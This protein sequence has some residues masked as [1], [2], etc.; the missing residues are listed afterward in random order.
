MVGGVRLVEAGITL[1]VFAPG[2]T[3]GVNNG[4]AQTS[5]MT[6]DVF[7]QRMHNN[8]GAVLK[9]AAQIRCRH[10]VVNNQSD[11]IAMA[12]FGQSFY[13]CHIA[14]R[15]ADGF[16]KDGSGFIVNQRFNGLWVVSAKANLQAVARQRVGKQIV[17]AAI[18]ARG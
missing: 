14:G 3:A 5:A 4:T 15:I 8:V 11:A 7:C 9:W 16:A 2:E 17:G 12:K 6:V 18:Q 1:L 13:V 10:S